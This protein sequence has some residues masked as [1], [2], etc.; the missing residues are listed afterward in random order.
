MFN[1]FVAAGVGVVSAHYIFK[2]PLEEYWREQRQLKSAD[3]SNASSSDVGGSGTAVNPAAAAPAP[4]APSTGGAPPPT[5][6][7]S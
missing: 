3:N 4:V 1:L 6:K 7:Q 2:V 5:T